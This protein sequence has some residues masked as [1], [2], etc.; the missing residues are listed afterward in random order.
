MSV[1]LLGIARTAVQVHE[2]AVSTAGHNI[3]NA[4]TEGYT[5][6]R[7]TLQAN[8]PLSTPLGSFGTGVRTT[9]VERIRSQW[10]D[11]SYRNESSG[12]HGFAL[13]RDM[14]AQVEGILGEPSES[15]LAAAM[16]AFWS[17]WSDLA[18]NPTS[19]AARAAVRQRGAHVAG[20]LNG[21]AERI[22]GLREN[23]RTRLDAGVRDV[24]SL[25]SQI[26][27]LNRQIVASEVTGHTAGDLRDARDRAIDSLSKLGPVRTLE[28]ADGSTQVLLGT[29][30]L[31]DGVDAK[32]LRVAGDGS[33]ASPLRVEERRESRGVEVEIRGGELGEMLRLLHD[34]LPAL[35]GRLDT[36]ADA[37]VRGVNA[38]HESGDPAGPPFFDPAGLDAGSIRLS[39]AVRASALAVRAGTDGPG[40]NRIALRLASLRTDPAEAV[41][42]GGTL[43]LGGR[44]FASYYGGLV[45]D[46]GL[47]VGAA[48][49]DASVAD[50]LARQAEL[51]RDEVGG[52]SIDE[53]MVQ[54]IRHQQAYTAAARLV[55]V[56]DEM[57][58]TVLQMV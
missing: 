14:L 46:L 36:L 27:D 29:T 2:K 6:R 16:D 35:R 40:D 50:V 39:T 51:R 21:F 24:N 48:G 58:K 52:V 23:G 31:V 9:T 54:M 30:T 18:N 41:G 38:I 37:L 53:E 47:D 42:P 32:Q 17:G 5:R 8:T 1:N 34:D 55:N 43:L 45:T 4:Q 7:V 19:D 10:L 49:R 15:G 26:A 57:I 44:S 3:S 11:E 33:P 25:A 28:N 12:A 22:Q 13:R 56:A 20:M